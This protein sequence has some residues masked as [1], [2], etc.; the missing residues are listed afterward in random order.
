M[1]LGVIPPVSSAVEGDV[2]EEATDSLS[3]AVDKLELS[4]EPRPEDQ[5]EEQDVVVEEEETEEL[6]ALPDTPYPHIFVVCDSADAFGAI[7]VG[8]TEYWQ[9]GVA[10]RN[11]IRLASAVEQAEQHEDGQE[12]EQGGS[13]ELESY[14]PGLPAIKVSLGI[15]RPFPLPHLL[16][17]EA[18]ANVHASYAGQNFRLPD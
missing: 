17:I 1:Q 2:T 15:V 18:L 8:H 4:S 12:E 6:E 11:L 13:L 10:A 7:K 9:A 3:A 14:A 5:G 16:F